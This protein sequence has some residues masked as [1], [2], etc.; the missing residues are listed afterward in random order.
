MSPRKKLAKAGSIGTKASTR[1]GRPPSKHR[2]VHTAVV[3]PRDL[4]ERLRKDGEASGKGLSHEVRLLLNL[5]LMLKTERDDPRT[6]SLLR[7]IRSLAKTLARDFGT[8]WD[9]H[10]YTYAAFRAGVLD[11][12]GRYE[13]VVAENAKAVGSDAPTAYQSPPELVGRAHAR[14]IG[15]SHDAGIWNER[16][17]LVFSAPSIDEG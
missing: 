1:R 5:A 17:E 10:P 15:L 16:G 9:Q 4:L 3:L 11:F 6:A 7:A 8:Q 13:K 14:V 2:M 12:L